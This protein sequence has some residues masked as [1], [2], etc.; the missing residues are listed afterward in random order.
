MGVLARLTLMVIEGECRRFG[1]TPGSE[2]LLLRPSDET[3]PL[4]DGCGLA[5]TLPGASTI[6]PTT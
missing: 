1:V 5:E 3:A 4:C 2:D 6:A